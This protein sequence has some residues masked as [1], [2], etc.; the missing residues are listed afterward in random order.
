LSRGVSPCTA[1]G[2]LRKAN[3]PLGSGSAAT[4]WRYADETVRLL[5]AR[6]LKL[7]GALRAAEKH[8]YVVLDGT[9]IPIERLA[10]DRPFYSGEHGR[11]GM[12]RQVIASPDGEIL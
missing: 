1:A 8:A 3:W 7:R 12:N 5:A 11:H 6:A 4:A 2:H 9:L 10:A